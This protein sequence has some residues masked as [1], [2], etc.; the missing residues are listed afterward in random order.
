VGLPRV[1]SDCGRSLSAVEARQEKLWLG[2]LLKSEEGRFEV[3]ANYRL[4][5]RAKELA[6]SAEREDRNRDEP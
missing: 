2:D 3:Y 6:E 4:E 1:H 5:Q